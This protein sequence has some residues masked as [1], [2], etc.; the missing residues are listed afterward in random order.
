MAIPTSGNIS[1]KEAA[2]STRS[3]DTAVSS[4]SSGSLHTLGTTGAISY[5]GGTAP[6]G[7]S[8]QTNTAPTGMREFYGYAHTSIGSWPSFEPSAWGTFA[9]AY[10]LVGGYG[11]AE[12]FASMTAIRDDS[13]NRIKIETYSGTA[14]AMATVYTNYI[15]YTGMSGATFAVKYNQTG[16]TYSGHNGTSDP[17]PAQAGYNVNQYYSLASNGSYHQF[18]WIAQRRS[19]G[20]DGYALV[21][22]LNM[23]FTLKITIDGVDYTAAS[24]SRGVDV[25]ARKGMEP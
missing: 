14:A 11:D 22:A 20:G 8:A 24:T 7:E 25:S 3:I 6:P 5:T 21:T 10:H 2:G 18:R 19:N 17:N 9:T 16:G 1:I 12:G 4:V 15:N 23:V 13:N